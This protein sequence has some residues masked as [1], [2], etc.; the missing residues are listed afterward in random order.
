MSALR[1]TLAQSPAP[2]VDDLYVVSVGTTA[3][4][5]VDLFAKFGIAAGSNATARPRVTVATAGVSY[6]VFGGA[7]VPTPAASTT[8][9]PG[10]TGLCRVIPANT[11]V[12]FVLTKER[13]FV[14]FVA[15][16]AS[17]RIQVHVERG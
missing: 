12:S 7:T 9:D 3:T 8:G 14:R 17:T 1:N 15:A 11:S 2:T 5:A 6:V 10:T 16:A 13:R 4:A